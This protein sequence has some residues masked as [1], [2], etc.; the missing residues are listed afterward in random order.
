[1]ASIP[2]KRTA[3]AWRSRRGCSGGL[4][5]YLKFRGD[6]REPRYATSIVVGRVLNGMFLACAWA[7]R[8]LNQ[9]SFSC[10][11][12]MRLIRSFRVS[13]QSCHCHRQMFAIEVAKDNISDR[14][15]SAKGANH[16]CSIEV[17]N[18]A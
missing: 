18:I 9:S 15:E 12:D 10:N 16:L 13:S 2:N 8:R 4:W 6:A 3:K 17:G 7:L 14:V 5:V 11:S 1:M